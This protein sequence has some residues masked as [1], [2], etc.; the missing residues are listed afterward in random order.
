[1]C[2]N[3]LNLFLFKFW[4]KIANS[5]V[6]NKFGQKKFGQKK[7]CSKFGQKRFLVRKNLWS[8]FF[9][10]IRTGQKYCWPIIVL[11]KNS[12]GEKNFG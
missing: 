12:F 3:Q 7:I 11:A 6:K 5:F 4:S 8:I 10:K 9:V 1:M 2:Q